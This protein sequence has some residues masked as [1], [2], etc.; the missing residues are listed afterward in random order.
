MAWKPTGPGVTLL[1]S[2]ALRH[3]GAFVRPGPLERRPARG[4]Y[5][6]RAA[7]QP[8]PSP[9]QLDIVMKKSIYWSAMFLGIASVS[10][11]LCSA[12]DGG[13]SPGATRN[14]DPVVFTTAQDRQN[15][16]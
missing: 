11:D 4:G 2:G 16:L 3:R 13:V 6:R 9:A 12:Q 5:H 7:A 1:G 15:M 14:N 10:P 8:A